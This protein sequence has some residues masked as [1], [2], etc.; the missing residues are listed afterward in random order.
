MVGD[1]DIWQN[2]ETAPKNECN[3]AKHA[4][5]LEERDRQTD[6]E[7]RK[8]R[9]WSIFIIIS[10]MTD[11]FKDSPDKSR[12]LR[13]LDLFSNFQSLTFT[14][15]TWILPLF[16]IWLT[17]LKIICLSIS[18]RHME[19]SDPRISCCDAIFGRRQLVSCCPASLADDSWFLAVLPSIADDKGPKERTLLFEVPA[20]NTLIN[21]IQYF[22]PKQ[23]F[24]NLIIYV[25][26]CRKNSCKLY[27]NTVKDNN[28]W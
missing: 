25:S 15:V 27:T 8:R 20:T 5:L 7:E 17:F 23:T 18:G 19:V 28:F 22:L 2:L 10:F 4:H 1:I 24:R 12:R 21:V 13:A 6:R 9:D 11:L 16:E 3:T 14:H 26:N